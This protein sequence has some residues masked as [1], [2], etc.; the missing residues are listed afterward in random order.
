M[1]ISIIRHELKQAV[2]NPKAWYF[3]ATIQVMLA[4]LF[5]WLLNNFL[6]NQ[7]ITQIEHYGITEEVIHPFYGWVALMIL[8]LLPAI[9]TQ[10]FCSE[11]QRGTMI[12]YYCS[13]ITGLQLLVAKFLSFNLLMIAAMVIISF[14]PITILISGSLDWG[15]FAAATFG[16]Y[17]MLSAA[18]AT[19]LGL[20]M[21][22][23]NILRSNIIIFLALTIFVMIEW[24]AQYTAGHAIF[25]QK[26]GLLSPLKTFLAGILSIRYIAFYL[27]VITC[28]LLLGTWRYTRR[29]NDV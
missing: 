16:V 26:F 29:W 19:S 13:P 27:F 21:F 17:L 8:M 1:I 24:A 3:L 18:L 2:N 7:A 11:K 22:M 20:S 14:M 23:N 25:L 28:F 10:A 6:A 4:I 15:Q 12:N 5:K 9:G